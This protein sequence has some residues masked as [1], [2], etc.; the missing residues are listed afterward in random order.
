M[1]SSLGRKDTFMPFNK[2]P[3]KLWALVGVSA[4]ISVRIAFTFRH[5]VEYAKY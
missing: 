3:R 2:A 4:D 1:I 5:A